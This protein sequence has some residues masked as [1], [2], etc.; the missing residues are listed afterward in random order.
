[1][2]KAVALAVVLGLSACG[3]GA[4][5]FCE[6]R[7]RA[8]CELAFECCSPKERAPLGVSSSLYLDSEDECVE[9][10][11]ATC[12]T[13]NAVVDDSV[14]LGRTSFDDVRA[15]ECLTALRA[16]AEACDAGAAQ[17]AQLL[18]CD[19]V[20]EGAVGDGGACAF[21]SE[22]RAG[23]TCDLESPPEVD[24]DLHAPLGACIEPPSESDECPEGV[25]ATGLF[26]QN[27]RCDV[28][29]GENDPCN[30]ECAP[31]LFC[32]PIEFVCTE[33]KTDGDEC[34]GPLECLSNVC[35]FP[36]GDDVARCG[37]VE[38]GQCSG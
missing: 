8:Q 6:E 14:A 18:P 3:G 38:Q 24:D 21:S 15:E 9:R 29:P 7:A 16:A 32:A 1:M 11:A 30:V 12:R 35:F 13:S 28:L 10:S 26:C 5:S 17:R 27:N 33:Q 36:V 20:S 31:G 2:T 22:C 4:V 19:D 25:C 23:G 37:G 34:N